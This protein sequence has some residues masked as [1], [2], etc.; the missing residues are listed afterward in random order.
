MSGNPTTVALLA[1]AIPSMLLVLRVVFNRAFGSKKTSDAKT[2]SI[3]I[4]DQALPHWK[5]RRANPLALYD[6]NNPEDIQCYCPATGQYLASVPVASTADI[7]CTIDKAHQAQKKYAKSSWSERR[8]VLKTISKFLNEHQ[9]EVARIACRDTGKTMLDASLGEIMITLEK[10]NWIVKNGEN[11]LKTSKRPGSSNILMSYKSGEVRY[12]PLGVVSAMV[13]WNYPLHNLMGPV[14]ASLMTGNGLVVK[15]SEAVVWSSQYFIEIAKQAL[16]VNGFS[17][18]LVQLAACWPKD[19]DYLT[20]HPGLSHITFIGSQPVAKLVAHAAA[21]S[22]TPVVA[23][24]G[25]KD[26][27][28]ILDDNHSAKEI[29][30]L[31]SLILRGTFQSSGQ[32][33]IGVE[34]VICQGKTYESLMSVL[35]NTISQFRLGSSIDQQEDIDMGATISDSRFDTLE[36]LV[37]S[38]VEQGARL[39]QGGTRYIHPKYPQG[40]YF[41]PTLLVDVTPDMEIAREEVFGP[42]LVM[43]KAESNEH[44]IELANSSHFGLGASVFGPYKSAS[45]VADNLRTG[46]VSINDFATYHICQLPFGG[47][48]GSGYGKFGGAEGLRGLCLEK[49]V[50]YDK[51]WFINTKIPRVLDYPIPDVKKAWEMVKAINEAGY[52]YSIYQ[53]IRAVFRLAK[54]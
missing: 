34:R 51:V 1:I 19:A 16:I 36:K 20:S 17:P 15:C 37:N 13:S 24:L 10:I 5:G 49:S 40:H 29:Q 28:I 9:E 47:V 27:L 23:E 4:P 50:A 44:S 31:A 41:K 18:D 8:Q 35:E 33:C 22:L 42:I 46:N 11:A 54:M 2:I 38:A 43:M 32:N 12:E 52:G 48:D 21:K 53:R 26:P 45:V 39:L 7:D 14:A 25:G 30:N 3:T 6:P